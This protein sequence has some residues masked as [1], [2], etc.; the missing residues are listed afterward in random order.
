MK[1][2]LVSRFP[3]GRQG[4]GVAAEFVLNPGETTTFD[5]PP[6]GGEWPRQRS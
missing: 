4:D 6:S 3:L 5:P 2:S 1:V